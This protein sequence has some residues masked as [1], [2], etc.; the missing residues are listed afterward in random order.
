MRGSVRLVSSLSFV[1]AAASGSFYAGGRVDA[2]GSPAASERS[3]DAATAIGAS[4]S[5]LARIGVGTSELLPRHPTGAGVTVYVF[6]GGIATDHPELAGRVRAGFDAFPN[7]PRVC[8]THGTAVAG[9]IAGRTLG[10]APGSEIVDVKIINCAVSRG[11][12]NGIV[13]AARWAV[14]D[15][16]RHPARPAIANWSFTVDTLGASPGVD[17]AIALLRRAGIL[18]IASAGN[19]D[20]DACRVS[21]ANSGAALIVGAT[22]L[23]TGPSDTRR[24]AEVRTP[25]TAWGKCVDLYAPGDS[26]PLPVVDNGRATTR[27]WTGTSMATGFVSGA[28]AL[29]LEQMPNT[30]PEALSRM[31]RREARNDVVDERVSTRTDRRGRLLQVLVPR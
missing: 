5:A 18:V 13:A 1:A 15:H 10:V 14:D 20:I 22:S 31:L 24:T 21:P 28:A 19:Y 4:R 16:Q 8:N 6:D 27:A 3:R 2:A 9:A 23:A 12:V 26:I 25:G 7:G 29:L 17:G 11:S 30:T